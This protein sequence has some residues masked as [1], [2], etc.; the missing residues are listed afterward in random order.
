MHK[1][2]FRL[3]VRIERA[4]SSKQSSK[5]TEKY[6]LLKQEERYLLISP[7]KQWKK[8]EVEK[9]KMIYLPSTLKRCFFANQLAHDI[10]SKIEPDSI[11][12]KTT[13]Y[14]QIQ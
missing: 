10:I 3:L 8:E 2:K 1:N 5:Q 7:S 9:T 14:S 6:L 13:N 4:K 12:V 11:E